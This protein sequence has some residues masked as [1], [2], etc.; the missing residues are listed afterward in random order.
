MVICSYLCGS[1]KS[2]G[3]NTYFCIGRKAYWGG[4]PIQE[5]FPRGGGSLP[6]CVGSDFIQ[7]Y[8]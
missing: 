8:C 6:A 3:N 5:V 4:F 2:I 1:G 7:N